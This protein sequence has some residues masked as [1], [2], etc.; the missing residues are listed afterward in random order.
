METGIMVSKAALEAHFSAQQSGSYTCP[1]TG[2]A[3]SGNPPSVSLVDKAVE[4]AVT[5]V[6]DAIR[7]K[8]GQADPSAT[9]AMSVS[10]REVPDTYDG[11]VAL[12][13]HYHQ[14]GNMTSVVQ[15]LVDLYGEGGDPFE[16]VSFETLI[17]RAIEPFDDSDPLTNILSIRKEISEVK[18]LSEEARAAILGFCDRHLVKVHR[19]FNDG[20]Q[21]KPMDLMKYFRREYDALE[22][23]KKKVIDPETGAVKTDPVTGENVIVELEDYVESRLNELSERVHKRPAG[24]RNGEV[25]ATQRLANSVAWVIDQFLHPDFTPPDEKAGQVLTGLVTA[26]PFGV[27]PGP[28]DILAV[29]TEPVTSAVRFGDR[30]LIL[31]N[32]LDFVEKNRDKL[33]ESAKELGIKIDQLMDFDDIINTLRGTVIEM[34]DSLI[35]SESSSVHAVG[36]YV[37]EFQALEH[38]FPNLD[39]RAHFGI[40]KESIENEAMRRDWPQEKVDVLM[41]LFPVDQEQSQYE[42]GPVQAEEVSVQEELAARLVETKI[43]YFNNESDTEIEGDGEEFEDDGEWVEDEDL[44][45]V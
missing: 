31:M 23:V 26:A 41:Q 16:G 11:F 28:S 18:Q 12:L 19:E 17:A 29:L 36:E 45:W 35:T 6:G 5:I 22:I 44:T 2:K 30:V 25:M 27:H 8:W 21:V 38:D 20:S 3:L 4:S 14:E 39:F 9:G 40:N 37:R 43:V 34:L 42:E 1:V 10:V 33:T 7:S 13:E 24:L 32:F 15:L